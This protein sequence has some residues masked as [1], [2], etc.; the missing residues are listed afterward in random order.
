[1]ADKFFFEE[2]TDGVEDTGMTW[3]EHTST[4]LDTL[5]KEGYIKETSSDFD[6]G[7]VKKA[8]TD[9]STKHVHNS[10]VDVEFG[11]VRTNYVIHITPTHPHKNLAHQKLLE[12]AVRSA[13]IILNNGIIPPNLDVDIFLPRDDYKIKSISFTIKDGA[14]AWNLDVSKI[15]KEAVPKLLDQIGKICMAAS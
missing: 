1:M 15:E 14:E 9:M 2:D 8:E 4:F 3:A 7:G 5:K 13:I 6:L 12:Q 10:L 11:T